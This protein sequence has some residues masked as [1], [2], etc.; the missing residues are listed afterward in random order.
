[1]YVLAR[2]GREDL[3]L[4]YVGRTRRGS[5]VECVESVA[6]PVPREEKW[7]LI[8]STL[9][10]CPVRCR[11]CDAG[12]EYRGAL[13]GEEILAQIEA[14]IAGR[15][16]DL[17]VPVPKFKIQFARMGEP[18]LNPAVLQ[19]L[20]QLP[21]K[22]DAPGLMPCLST[23]LPR[24]CESFFAELGEIK[25]SLYTGGSF[26]LQFSLHTTDP[27]RRR[28]LIPYPVLNFSDAARLGERFFQSGD[29]RLGLNFAAAQGCPIEPAVLAD[30]FDP[31][32]FAVK[33]TPLNPTGRSGHH[34]LSS[35]IDPRTGAGSEELVEG[36][37]AAGYE[38][39]LSLG[40]PEEDAIGSN[41]GQYVSRFRHS[42][43]MVQA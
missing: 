37:R 34:Q 29:R 24:G 10:G 7:V 22:Y 38:V 16:P 3:A 19:V 18:A 33:L 20:R 12:G 9:Q 41:C 14:L 21:Q 26:Q 2:Y 28:E 25:N 8:V 39:I 23:V 27:D 5:L 42:Q 6:P 1:V 40:Q 36:L 4:L 31:K 15:Y 35:R 11:M 13:T 32:I 30:H 43:A 17:K